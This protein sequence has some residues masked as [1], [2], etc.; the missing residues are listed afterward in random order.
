MGPALVVY[1]NAVFSDRDYKNLGSVA[2][3]V[4]KDIASLIHMIISLTP[5]EEFMSFYPTLALIVVVRMAFD[6]R[7]PNRAKQMSPTRLESLERDSTLF[8]ISLV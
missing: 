8:I 7:L 2:R 6:T 4:L 1:N 3:Q 5:M